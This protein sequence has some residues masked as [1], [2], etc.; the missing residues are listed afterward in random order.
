MGFEAE[1]GLETA[2]QTKIGRKTGKIG[3][4]T[5]DGHGS[6]R[7]GGRGTDG[8][9]GDAEARRGAEI[10]VEKINL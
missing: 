3:K 9:H 4:S 2:R 5:T 7:M 6:T 10:A 8:S 1:N